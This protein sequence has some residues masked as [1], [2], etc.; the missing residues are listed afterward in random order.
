MSGLFYMDNQVKKDTSGNYSAGDTWAY[1]LVYPW[2][3]SGSL[4]NDENRPTDKGTRSAVLLKKKISNL[5][6][7]NNNV[8]LGVSPIYYDISKPQ[9]FS[10][11][12]LKLTKIH[13]SY[14]DRDVSYLGN[15]DTVIT[16]QSYSICQS[17]SFDGN[18]VPTSGE[19]VIANSSE[20]VRIKYKS[21][22]HLVFSLG[23]SRTEIEL[24]PR[25]NS[26]IASE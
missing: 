18:I 25:H 22:P 15:I 21:S 14:L 1:W 16:G 26:I 13:P 2:H 7:F 10:S 23:S 3:R 9:L 11:N 6:F 19:N 17:S 20:P 8:N 12:E 24:L 4:N 5:K